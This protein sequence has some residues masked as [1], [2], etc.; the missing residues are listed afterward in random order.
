LAW[1]YSSSLREPPLWRSTRF[2]LVTLLG[3]GEGHQLERVTDLGSVGDGEDQPFGLVDL[4]EPP[5]P[6]QLVALVVHRGTPQATRLQVPPMDVDG[7]GFGAEPLGEQVRLGDG[8]PH[9][10]AGGVEPAGEGIAALRIGSG[11]LGHLRLLLRG[12]RVCLTF[13]HLRAIVNGGVEQ[14]IG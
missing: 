9:D 11:R 2:V 10:R 1:P 7:R 6:R 3:E 5:R 4:L 12:R 8:L 13:A 14:P